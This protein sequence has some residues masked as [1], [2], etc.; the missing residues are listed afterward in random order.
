[1]R[2]GIIGA[3][4]VGGTLGRAWA[5]N[6]H[7]VRFGVPN[8]TAPKIADLLKATG[9]KATAG[10]VAEAAAHGEVVVLATPWAATENAVRQA[11]NLDGK[12]I[13]D[14]TNP[15]K[16]DLSGLTIGHTTSGA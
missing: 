7:E 12:I 2:I 16:D 5:A 14:C 10:S 9:G 15:L 4:N 8:P 6:G 3:G 1:M 11:G 13:L